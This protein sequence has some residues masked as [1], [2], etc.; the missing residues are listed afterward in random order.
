MRE[1]ECICLF[2][3]I[4]FECLQ[5]IICTIFSVSIEW[6]ILGA[7]KL[8]YLELELFFTFFLKMSQR[9][10]KHQAHEAN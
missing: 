1:Q 8:S 5:Q 4:P 9:Q 6:I 3:L 10:N 2:I 7:D